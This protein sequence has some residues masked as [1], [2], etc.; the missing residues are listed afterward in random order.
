MKLLRSVLYTPGSNLRAIKKALSLDI[1]GLILDLEDAVSPINKSEARH[2][3]EDVLTKL[4]PDT[5]TLPTVT[6]RINALNTPW[7]HHDLRT[8]CRYRKTYIYK[9]YIQEK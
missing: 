6:V 7:G 9:V 1:D 2:I 4:N 3:V 8:I 5:T